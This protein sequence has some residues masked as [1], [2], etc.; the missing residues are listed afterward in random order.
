MLLLSQQVMS[1]SLQPHRLQQARL[2]Y[3]SPYIS[4]H[5]LSFMYRSIKK[6]TTI[7]AP[8]LGKLGRTDVEA[9]TPVLW[10]SDAKS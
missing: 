3:P 7:S 5:K 6:S 2:S 4:Y 1:N 8:Q 9:E 10:P